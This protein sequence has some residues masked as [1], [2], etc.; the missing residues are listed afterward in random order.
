MMM[1][2]MPWHSG[3][4]MPMGMH[5]GMGMGAPQ[6]KGFS[7]GK[8]WSPPECTKTAYLDRQLRTVDMEG[9][10]NATLIP[11]RK[12]P[13]GNMELLLTWERPWNALTNSFD[14]VCW[15]TMGGKRIMKVE[16]MVD[17][18]AIRCFHEAAD[19]FDQDVEMPN[20]SGMI[21]LTAEA[22]VMW[23]PTG[24]NAFMIFEVKEGALDDLPQKFTDAKEKAGPQSD[25]RITAQG[26]K[27]WTKQIER[28]EWVPATDLA[29]EAAKDC[30]DLLRNILK[31]EG[32]QNF[33]QGK[34]DPE[35]EFP[36]GDPAD[37]L[38]R[39]SAPD[40][41]GGK[42]KGGKDSKGKA[43]KG[44]SSK[45]K[46]FAPPMAVPPMMGGKPSAPMYPQ[47]CMA[48]PMAP[49]IPEPATDPDMQLQLYGEQLFVLIQ[50]MVPNQYVA[51][52]ITGMLLELPTNELLMNLTNHKELSKRVEEAVALLREDGIV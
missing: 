20:V 4:M 51:Q 9:Y 45:G 37:R 3:G 23:Y 14:T 49:V 7:K 48:P 6:T 39:L 26:V 35:K 47:P 29:P 18:T 17:I 28:L 52:K 21:Q 11:Y 42:P 34:I 44:K 38:N 41:R 22:F 46:G 13:D 15:H 43:A 50:P 33:L 12:T 40:H 19:A 25:F 31:I 8:G 5:M 27:K 2:E 10:S 16:Q 32:F 30:S 36:Q 1:Y 24:R